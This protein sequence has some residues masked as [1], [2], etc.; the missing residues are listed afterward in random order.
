MQ[1]ITINAGSFVGRNVVG[2]ILLF[3]GIIDLTIVVTATCAILIIGMIW[4]SSAASFVVLGLL[5]G[6]F[7]GM[8]ECYTFVCTREPCLALDHDSY[9]NDGAHVWAHVRPCRFWVRR[10]HLLSLSL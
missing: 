7:S 1:S 8:S 10:F 2:T 9:R 4:L 3:V 5:Y 6:V